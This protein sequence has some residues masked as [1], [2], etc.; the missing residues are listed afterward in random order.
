MYQ[1]QPAQAVQW[2]SALTQEI[3]RANITALKSGSRM[4]EVIEWYYRHQAQVQH[5]AAPL[6]SPIA[7]TLSYQAPGRS[8]VMKESEVVLAVGNYSFIVN[9]D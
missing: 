9:I 3:E 7:A 4:P 8:G 5:I 2:E 1:S 6:D